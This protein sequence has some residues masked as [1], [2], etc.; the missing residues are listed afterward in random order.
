MN[1][2]HKLSKVVWSE[3]MYLGPHHFQAQATFFEN[4]LRFVAGT[5]RGNPYGFSTL[6]LDPEPLRNGILSLTHARGLFADGL[7]FHM[8]ESDPLPPPRDIRAAFSPAQDK[9]MVYLALPVWRPGGPNCQEGD[10]SSPGRFAAEKQILPDDTTGRDTQAVA[11]GRKNIQ[12]LT[13]QDDAEDFER[14]PLA[15]IRRSGAGGFVA[16]ESFVPPCLSVRASARLEGMLRTLVEI[17]RSKSQAL[18]MASRGTTALRAGLSPGQVAS[19]WFLHAVNSGLASLSHLATSAACHPDELYREM[20]KL[21]GALCSFGLQAT[22]DS[23]PRYDHAEPAACFDALESHIRTH[24]DLVVQVNCVQ[25]PLP[26]GQTCYYNATLQDERLF[27]PSRWFLGLRS[28][29]GEAEV[30]H[31]GPLLMKVCSQPFVPELVRRA[32]HGLRLT[33]VPLPPAALLPRIDSQYFAI[34][35]AGPCWDHIRQT[36]TVGVYIPDEIAAAE[37]ELLVVLGGE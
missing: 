8:P 18:T 37:P 21:A 11:L 14:L 17:L 26:P 2:P 32:V 36:K 6:R 10:S 30:I 35:R 5:L 34:N 20:S 4:A 28:S 24:L 13:A 22:V 9:L 29:S 27:G 31:K 23:L 3:G 19:Y 1:Q 15:R 7:A 25:I 33:H 16:D 12:I